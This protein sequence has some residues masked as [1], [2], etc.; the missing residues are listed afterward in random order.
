[1]LAI[2]GVG[3]F[4]CDLAVEAAVAL[5]VEMHQG[6]VVPEASR[7]RRRPLPADTV[8]DQRQMLESNSAP[9]PRRASL[10]RC[11]RPDCR[12]D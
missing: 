5:E 7:E 2:Q 9:G 12:R 8:A 4:D 3:E 11:R 10:S 6:A 1:M